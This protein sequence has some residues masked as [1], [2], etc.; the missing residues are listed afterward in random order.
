M[1]APLQNKRREL[2]VSTAK[3]LDADK[4]IRFDERNGMALEWDEMC[5]RMRYH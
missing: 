4:M 3:K 5:M 1:V 2:I